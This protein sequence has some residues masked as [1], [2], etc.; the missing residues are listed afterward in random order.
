M[1]GVRYES[2]SWQEGLQDEAETPTETEWSIPDIPDLFFGF[3]FG[4]CRNSTIII[5]HY[6]RSYHIHHSTYYGNTIWFCLS[7]HNDPST[8]YLFGYRK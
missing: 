2:Y 3:D 6:D 8:P 1:A 4:W 7:V 5:N